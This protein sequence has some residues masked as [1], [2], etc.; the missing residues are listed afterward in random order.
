MARRKDL[1]SKEQRHTC[2]SHIRSTD[3]GIELALR[4]ALWAKGY[5]YR[6]N[7]HD[8]PGSPER[9]MLRDRENDKELL[10]LGW[11]VIHFWGLDILSDPGACVKVIE[12][13]IFDDLM[14]QD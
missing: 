9:N 11:T 2:M 13:A 1:L 12:E 7:A 10:F 4:K 14:D 6:K 8:L 3:T 5:H